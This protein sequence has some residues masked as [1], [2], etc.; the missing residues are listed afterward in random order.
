M[1]VYDISD[2]TFYWIKILVSV[3]LIIGSLFFLIPLM[4]LFIN[5]I[6]HTL[7]KVSGLHPLL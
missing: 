5:S 1:K 6:S 2:Y 3:F 4:C 7:L